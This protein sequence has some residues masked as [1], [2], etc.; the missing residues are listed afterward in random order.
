[1]HTFPLAPSTTFENVTALSPEWNIKDFPF[2]QT[3]FPRRVH[4]GLS[5]WK[6]TPEK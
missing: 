6:M 3:S 5:S 2:Q 1:M 4:H